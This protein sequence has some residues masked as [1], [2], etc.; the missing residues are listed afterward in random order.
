LSIGFKGRVF[1]ENIL[2]FLRNKDIEW[3][4]LALVIKKINRA[5]HKKTSIEKLVFG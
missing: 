5:Q 3:I 2:G 4:R 1:L